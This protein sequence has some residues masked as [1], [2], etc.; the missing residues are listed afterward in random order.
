[1]AIKCIIFDVG[2]VLLKEKIDVVH[3]VI[4]K[5]LGKK[6]FDRK[7]IHHKKSL[8]GKL[9]EKQL[10]AALSKKYRIP[11]VKLKR[12]SDEKFL[13]IMKTNKGSLKIAKT[14]KKNYTTCILSNVT[15]MHKKHEHMMEIYS[16]FDHV[17]LS[18]DIGAMKPSPKIFKIALKKLD[19]KP[20]ECIYIEDREEFLDTPKKLGMNVILFKSANQL[21]KDLKKHG[22]K[23]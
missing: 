2:G 5:E 7:D 14:L 8:M 4:N 12:L 23:I 15:P 6:V 3:N 13:K 21:R 22:V 9:T 11:A 19:A 20:R 1:M 10:L 17:V 16:F 18:C